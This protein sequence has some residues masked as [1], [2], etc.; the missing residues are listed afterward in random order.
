MHILQISQK[1][2]L[3]ILEYMNIRWQDSLFHARYVNGVSSI[4]S[5]SIPVLGNLLSPTYFQ[6]FLDKVSSVSSAFFILVKPCRS[7][8]SCVMNHILAISSIV[9][10]TCVVLMQLA[11]SL[12][13]RFYL[14]I[15]KCKH[16]S[17]T[18]AQQVKF[19]P[20]EAL[21][22]LFSTFLTTTFAFCGR[23]FWTLK[24]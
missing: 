12:G 6:Y 13:P 14:N 5:S 22:F 8:L 15:Y 17:E 2:H 10:I 24:L 3:I 9:I 20:Y 11:A 19:I 4:L 16:I 18:G 21:S 1:I 23:C 7:L